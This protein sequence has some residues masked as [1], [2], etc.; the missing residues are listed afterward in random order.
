MTRPRPELP[1]GAAAHLADFEDPAILGASRQIA[2]ANK[3]FVALVQEHTGSPAEVV[4]DLRGVAS[5]L[6]EQRG[7][8]TQAIPNALAQ[9]L[10]GSAA[11]NE[12]NRE[13]FQQQALRSLSGYGERSRRDRDRVTEIGVTL[14]ANAQRI[15][16]Y[17]YSSSVAAILAQ[18]G[19]S[20]TPPT[21]VIPEARSLNGGRRFVEDLA[22]TKLA[23]EFVPDAALGSQ[24]LSCDL[25]L[26]GAETV[27]ADGSCYNT[28]GSLGVALA[29][30]FWRVA[31]YVP[32]TLIKLDTRTLWGYQRPQPLLHDSR[33]GGLTDG[34]PTSLQDRVH[35]MSPDLDRVPASLITGYITEAG[36]VPPA[37][38]SMHAV[39]LAEDLNDV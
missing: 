31:L 21:V 34:W 27:G 38:M 20:A 23:I 12:L 28:V 30:D 3:L 19:A 35:V 9:M 5:Y 11:W 7:A 4:R 29:C 13:E 24:L 32:T 36:L 22:A 33:L 26:I 17:D 16:A 8:S 37:A 15:L 2:T 14:A 1:P 18:L 39:R 10:A 6:I 25:A